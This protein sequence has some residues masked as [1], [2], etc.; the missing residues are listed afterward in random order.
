VARCD[1]AEKKLV[2]EEFRSAAPVIEKQGEA[3][4]QISQQLAADVH[5]LHAKLER[6]DILHA[7]ND[8]MVQEK[9]QEFNG[10]FK[11]LQQQL[12][13]YRTS[14]TESSESL[15][16]QLAAFVVAKNEDM[17]GVG[18]VVDDM[19]SC[20][21]SAANAVEKKMKAHS[22]TSDKTTNA[23]NKAVVKQTESAASAT[24][25]AASAVAFAGES[26]HA[27]LQTQQT[28]VADMQAAVTQHVAMFQELA[29]AFVEQQAGIVAK[30][31]ES[32]A[33]HMQALQEQQLQ[34]QKHIDDLKQQ[35]AAATAAAKA[36]V[37][38]ALS[39]ALDAGKT[40]RKTLTNYHIDAAC[41]LRSADD[42]GRQRCLVHEGDAGERG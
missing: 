42:R 18:Q 25:E 11:N 3:L 32:V 19:S 23:M 2:V 33:Q 21:C 20:M 36:R 14:F 13:T 10:Q 37:M 22:K 34:Q 27:A 28:A 5:G 4:L 35:H 6:K 17:H 39:L 30:L 24:S 38:D 9:L 1:L 7:R 29:A 8:D 26:T 40:Q 16:A 12:N 41:R 31:Q 15:K